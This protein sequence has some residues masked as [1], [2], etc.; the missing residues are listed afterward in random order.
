MKEYTEKK[1]GRKSKA[2]E[3]HRVGFFP[4]PINLG[5]EFSVLLPPSC[6]EIPMPKGRRGETG[7]EGRREEGNVRL[8]YLVPC[9][10]AWIV[11]KRRGD[12]CST[13]LEG[14]KKVVII[15]AAKKCDCV[16]CMD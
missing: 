3:R 1:Y 2:R 9:R 10:K 7:K 8:C 16:G 11:K 13:R 15:W 5:S 6:P 12:R 14:R 4:R